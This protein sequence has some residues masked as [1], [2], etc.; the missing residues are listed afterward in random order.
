[1]RDF[2]KSAEQHQSLDVFVTIDEFKRWFIRCT[3]FAKSY[4]S[5]QEESENLASEALTILWQKQQ[6]GE[7]IEDVLPFLFSVVRNKALHYLRHKYVMAFAHSSMETEQTREIQLRIRTLDA[8]DPHV[9]YSA[10]VQTIMQKELDNMS[11]QTR[12]AFILSRFKGLSNQEIA[13]VMGIGVK[14]VEYHM[15]KALKALRNALGDYL[16]FVGI[17]LSII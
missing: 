17:F 16:P 2:Q 1:M 7:V 8:C 4:I 3:L 5:D 12:K 10:D 11:E 15:T 6:S 9:L 14:A 13:D